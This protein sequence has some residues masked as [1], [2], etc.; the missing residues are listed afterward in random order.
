MKRQMREAVGC[1][2]LFWLGM[3]PASGSPGDGPLTADD[4]VALA[5]AGNP[6][7]SQMRARYEAMAQVPA[8]VGVLPDP[9]LS[10]NALNFPT[11]SFE[12][13]QEPMTQI[14]VGISQRFPFPGKLGLEEQASQADAD[15]ALDGFEEARLA[16]VRAVRSS[17]W[18]LHYLD[19]ALE[20][21]AQN[22][23]LLR[24]FVEIAKTKYEVGDGLQQDVLLA[25]LELSRLLDREIQ[26]TGM[27]RA[28]EAQ[29]LKL[30]DRPAGSP[31]EL[32]R[33]SGGALPPP[34]EEAALMARA[35]G[36]R[37]RLAELRHRIAA[38]QSRLD[39]ARKDFY[40]DF[41]VGAAY[42]FRGGDNP[43][44]M[45]GGRADLLT[46][47]LSM[48]LP[49][50]P[51]RKRGSA[52]GQRTSELLGERYALDDALGAVQAEITRANADYVLARDEF[53]LFET[54][55]LPQARQT[56]Q[57]MLAAYQVNQVDFLNL[58]RSQ[59]TLFDYE[60]QYWRAQSAAHQ[61]LARLSAAVGEGAE[62]V[63]REH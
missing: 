19:R 1:L 24:H 34:T 59:I 45:G 11:D 53:S 35:E 48:N 5:V 6:S 31:V 21:V 25:Q 42:G 50:Y 10:V 37:P 40:P 14:Q 39:L 9:V 60:L 30:T 12:Y 22:Q 49:L 33:V 62:E 20:I 15:A 4:A 56:V 63:T 57:S 52:V 61:A 2:A 47:R 29:L 26:L 38:A 44:H 7:L 28:E 17:W 51:E 8:Q 16:L 43:P 18:T 55:I 23:Q 3:S 32:P 36:Q 13:R 46:L 58:V 27:R 54:G 41:T